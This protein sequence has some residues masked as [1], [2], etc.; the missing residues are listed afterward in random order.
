MPK[1]FSQ[2][3]VS[4]SDNLERIGNGGGWYC[5]APGL[6]VGLQRVRLRRY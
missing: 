2:G 6:I 3:A 1:G 5:Y 4:F